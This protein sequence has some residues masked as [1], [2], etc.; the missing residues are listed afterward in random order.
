MKNV[1]V[2]VDMQ[3]DFIDGSL[4]TPEARAIVDGVV[5]RVKSFAGKV[6]FTRDTHGEDYMSTQ[7]GRLLP[8]RHCI[9][10]TR[11]HEIHDSLLPYVKSLIDKPTF[12]SL[13]L[14]EMLS[15]HADEI[16]TV[17]LIGLCTDVCVIS[18]AMLLKAALPEASIR[19]E[20]GL[21]A[22]VTPESHSNALAAMRACQISVI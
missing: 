19:V 4:G 5:E 9:S 12:G 13:K 11:G 6:I 2:V 14:S 17:T 20:A 7:E 15:R 3:N 10:G 18:N 16:E 8:I 22:G 1:L 21:C